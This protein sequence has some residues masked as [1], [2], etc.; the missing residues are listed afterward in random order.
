MIILKIGFTMDFGIISL[1]PHL[2]LG[3]LKPN[4]GGANTLLKTQRVWT[5]NIKI[6]MSNTPTI[7]KFM[8]ECVHPYIESTGRV[9]DD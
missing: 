2:R 5:F 6:G 8:R 9:Y 7:F 3:V 4:A 1:I